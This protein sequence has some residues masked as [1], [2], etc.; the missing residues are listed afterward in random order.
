MSPMS[1]D[2]MLPMSLHRTK[3]TGPQQGHLDRI[4]ISALIR[5]F[6]QTIKG[7]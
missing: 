2:R 7:L 6:N 3:P 5:I 4:K 1:L